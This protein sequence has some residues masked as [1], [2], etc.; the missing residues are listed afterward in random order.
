MRRATF[1]CAC[2]RC[3][4]AGNKERIVR[5]A[6]M[7]GEGSPMN[8][9]MN[10]NELSGARPAA[11]GAAASRRT[12]TA[13][14]IAAMALSALLVTSAATGC[15]TASSDSSSTATPTETEQA[16]QA[17]DRKAATL[18]SNVTKDERFGSAVTELTAD[19]LAQAGYEFG[20]SC[21]IVFSNGYTLTDVPYFDG[22]YVKKGAP[23]LVAYPKD[24]TVKVA[25]YNS[26]LWDASGLG[27][28]GTVTITLNTPGK[29]RS[30]YEVLS[31]TYSVDRADYA[32][33]EQFCN[34]R[35][36]SGGNL[37]ENFLY[38]GASP[39]DDSRNRAAI[40]DSLLEKYGIV[41]VI[42]LADR[43]S[44]ME[45]YFASDAFSSN[46]TR[47][48][49]ESGAD[50]VLGMG[51]DYDASAY[52]ESIA[53]G[54]RHLINAGGPAYIHCMEGKDR[55]GFVC[56]LVEALAGASYDEM[57]DDYMTTYANYYGITA[58]GT[59]EKYNAIVSL[60]FNAFA[61]YLYGLEYDGLSDS[62][63]ELD[64]SVLASA[65]YVEPARKY[66]K[67]C[68]MT[69]DEIDQLVKTITK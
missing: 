2:S 67:N 25:S 21:D 38:R 5:F 13:G 18:T 52:K 28:S 49:Y 8:D 64:A 37:K 1:S 23:V 15:T 50:V 60:Y 12:S 16:S 7:Q 14:L 41:D 11:D 27:D 19:A 24:P 4:H 10:A 48:L 20:D 35:A 59:P 56:L 51:A 46:Y 68:G 61:Q 3:Y 43:A 63:S 9:N 31:Q 33:D 32:S 42:D 39:V 26:H 47:G 69:D 55:T 30:T 34:F 53:A 44:D 58:D 62:D 65:D 57:R 40:T 22:Y 17:Q 36:L 6:R 54:M 29:Y 45:K 66:L